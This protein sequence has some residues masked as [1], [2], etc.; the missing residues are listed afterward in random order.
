MQEQTRFT[1]AMNP[2]MDSHGNSPRRPSSLPKDVREDRFLTKISSM[3]V[4][5]ESND[6]VASNDGPSHKMKWRP[7]DDSSENRNADSSNCSY[8]DAER[9]HPKLICTRRR[10]RRRKGN[11]LQRTSLGIK[12]L[13][14]EIEFASTSS[15]TSEDDWSDEL[16]NHDGRNI[17]A[18]ATIEEIFGQLIQEIP[19]PSDIGW[20]IEQQ[21][22]LKSSCVCISRSPPRPVM[23][24]GGIAQG[25]HEQLDRR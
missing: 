24:G 13:P 3:M 19:K 2:M 5:Q 1:L 11:R 7:Y 4:E 16:E 22:P 20:K 10:Q 14:R 6:R 23:S 15:C 17:S 8:N 18:T 9:S 21:E 12:S 25:A